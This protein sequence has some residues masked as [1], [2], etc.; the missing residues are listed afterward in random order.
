M[1]GFS[2]WQRVL[3]VE[4]TYSLPVL[5]GTEFKLAF[6]SSRCPSRELSGDGKIEFGLCPL[7]P[8]GSSLR[9]QEDEHVMLKHLFHVTNVRPFI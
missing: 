6:Q 1:L 9:G 3:W 5:R 8:V 2:S 4:Y 7:K